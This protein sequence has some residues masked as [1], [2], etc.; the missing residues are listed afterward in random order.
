MKPEKNGLLQ[1][2]DDPDSRYWFIHGR[3]YDLA[4]FLDAHPGGRAA[5]EV[6]QGRDCTELFESYHSL[7]PWARTRL[8]AFEVDDERPCPHAASPFDWSETPF[9]DDLS[10]RV[11]AYFRRRGHKTPPRAWALLGCWM[12]LLAV[13]FVGWLQ[14][15]WLSLLALPLFYWLGPSNLMHSG[16]HF[17]LSDRPWVNRLGALAGGVHIAPATWQR[18]HNV[19]HHA[20]TNLDGLDPDLAHF[21]HLE[22]PM[23]G[24][25]LA[26]SQPWRAKYLWHRWA[27]VVQSTMTT[28]GPSLLNTPE[29]LIDGKVA[30]TTAYLFR[31]RLQVAVH[32]VGRIGVIAVLMVLPF[33]LFGPVKAALFAFVPLALHGLLYFGFS[34]VSH[35]NAT[36][37]PVPGA[38]ME[39]AEHQVR[40]AHDY[41]TTSRFWNVFSIGLNNQVVHHLFPQ[42]APWH[43]PRLAGIVEATCADHGVPYS[44]S[45]TWIEA[46]RGLLAHVAELNGEPG[47]TP[48][49][50]SCPFG[51][52]RP[53]R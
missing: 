12:A 8:D 40:T 34:Q 10:A 28:M 6:T 45:A 50:A 38:R 24:F 15:Y 41:S 22:I 44:T 53:E 23:P 47:P 49:A 32:I 17:A 3:R 29:Y 30:K 14:G 7:C 13:S 27:M 16:G 5:L 37:V 2:P 9:Y 35:V 25:R 39:W 33:F 36:C 19:G 26:R 20:Y 51:H 18:Q 1:D 43:Y 11:R 52:G 31:D 46:F 48:D 42:V 21:Q 4:P